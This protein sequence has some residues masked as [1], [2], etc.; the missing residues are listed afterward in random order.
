MCFRKH[1]DDTMIL[2]R[3]LNASGAWWR[4]SLNK[5]VITLL[6]RFR[7]LKIIISFRWKNVVDTSRVV[8]IEAR[9]KDGNK[10][11]NSRAKQTNTPCVAYLPLYNPF[12]EEKPRKS[13]KPCDVCS[14]DR[15]LIDFLP[16]CMRFEWI[17]H[18]RERKQID[19]FD[20][21]WLVK[22]QIKRSRRRSFC[23]L[24]AFKLLSA[25]DSRCGNVNFWFFM[26]LR[27]FFVASML[28][29]SFP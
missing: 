5:N 22:P 12:R 17:E 6:L 11:F 9:S 15:H 13:I 24:V 16:R 2:G 20:C 3:V 27:C 1:K 8:D 14:I 10:C 19:L 25:L 7:S 28:L 4:I 21:D 23:A 18:E 26:R 29:D